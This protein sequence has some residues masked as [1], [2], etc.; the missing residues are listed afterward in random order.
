MNLFFTNDWK[1]VSFKN[2]SKENI[3]KHYYLD[4]VSFGHDVETAYLVLEASHV[5][6]LKDE[7]LTLQRGKKWWTMP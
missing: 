3:R 2:T 6:G 7:D 4:H 5:L 1:P